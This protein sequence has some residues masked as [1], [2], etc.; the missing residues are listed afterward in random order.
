[1]CG[2]V[3][4]CFLGQETAEKEANRQAIAKFIFTELMIQ[5]QTRGEDATGVA[6]LFN[7]GTYSG[8][9]MGIKASDFIFKNEGVEVTYNNFLN[10][11]KKIGNKDKNKVAKVILG[12]CRKT[13]VGSAFDNNNN[14]PIQIDPIVGIHN[15]TLKN[16]DI[17]FDKLKCKRDGSVDSE[18]IFRL[19]HSL[20][21]GGKIAF[22]LDNLYETAEKLDGTYA[23]LAI[24]GNNP[25]QLGLLRDTRPIELCLIKNLNMVIIASEKPFINSVLY[26]YKKHTDIYNKVLDLNTDWPKITKDDIEF[27]TMDDDSVAV[28]DMAS[29]LDVAPFNKIFMTKKVPRL[30]KQWQSIGGTTTYN[31][32][33]YYNRHNQTTGTTPNKDEIGIPAAVIKLP[34]PAP[35]V[36][37]AGT[38]PATTNTLNVA[39]QNKNDKTK[40]IGIIWVAEKKQFR[41]ISV[42]TSVASKLGFMEISVDNSDS[43]TPIKDIIEASKESLKEDDT[44]DKTIKIVP[45]AEIVEIIVK[46]KDATNTKVTEQANTKTV[47]MDANPILI[48][49]ANIYSNKINKYDDLFEVAADLGFSSENGFMEIVKI[50]PKTAFNRANRVF[51][52]IGFKAGFETAMQEFAKDK[53]DPVV[54]I[55][56]KITN[57]LLTAQGNSLSSKKVGTLE[58]FIKETLVDNNISVSIDE[59]KN[60][61]TDFEIENSNSLRALK[62]VVEERKA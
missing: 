32:H 36:P 35:T 41:D 2:I 24:N 57:V 40:V 13:S 58:D 18:A 61:Y 29:T 27:V 6:A 20:T 23:V 56:K 48:K 9:K 34:P 17:I 30:G 5:T 53:R 59:I 16:Y 7:D 45:S 12:H 47:E 38:T 14:H 15:G 25:F 22:S 39:P 31:Q 62:N 60:I 37:V 1:M 43:I 4:I 26:K 52:E 54:G 3:G 33:N 49:H 11:W 44:V 10:I 55:S 19:M 8:L 42:E 28:L 50:S 51:K 21:N 46:D